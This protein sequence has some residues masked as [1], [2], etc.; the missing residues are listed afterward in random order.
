MATVVAAKPDPEVLVR[1]L[2]E[3]LG[4]REAGGKAFN[5]SRAIAVGLPVPPGIVITNVVFQRFLDETTLRRAIDLECRGLDARFPQDLRKRSRT[6]GELIRAAPFPDRV[7]RLLREW[8]NARSSGT[9]IAV[10][11][12]AVGEDSAQASFAGQLDSRLNID[13]FEELESAV[14][15]CWA[16]YWSERALFYQAALRSG[17]DGMGV[18][19][20]EQ[21]PAAFAGV[22]FTRS[23]DAPDSMLGEY[24][25]GLADTLVSGGINPGRFVIGR[26]DDAWRNERS[27]EDAA[28]GNDTLLLNHAAMAALKQLGMKLESAFGGPQD[29]EWALDRAGFLWCVQSRPI[30]AT[31]LTPRSSPRLIVWSNAN[32]SENFPAPISPLLYSIASEG[33]YHY[34]RNLCRAFGI[35]P[36]RIR[37]MEQPLRN[38][39]GVHGARMYYNLTSI[40][41]I[42]RAAPFGD[43]LVDW[44]NAFTGA[45]ER[46]SPPEQP[47]LWSRTRMSR[48][49][50]AGEAVRMALKTTWQYLFLR[51]CIER[52]ERTAGEFSRRT[53]PD[54]LDSR[55]L[56]ELLE[57]LRDFL[58]I[59]RNRWTDASLA[60]AGSMICYGALKAL[61][62]RALPEAGAPPALHNTLLKALPDVVSGVPV[63]E[64]WNLS[65]LIR[66]DP[67]LAGLFVKHDGVRILDHLRAN[68]AFESFRREFDRFLEEWGFRSSSELML[69]V[70][71]FQENPAPL[72]DILKGYAS[73][74]GDSPRDIMRKHDAERVTETARLMDALGRQ[75]LV[76][77][78]PLLNWSGVTRIVLRW[79]QRSIVYRERARLQQALL[80]SRCRRIALAIGARLA[81]TGR[82]GTADDIFF[83]TYQEIEALGSGAAMFPHGVRSL[84]E[85][86]RAQH[87]ELSA[88]CPPDSFTLPEGEYL[89]AG[90][91]PVV[92]GGH[93]DGGGTTLTGTG[94]CGGK[95]TGPAAIL[96]S[97]AESHLIRAGD[98]LVTKQTDPGWAPVFFLIKGLVIERGGMLSHGAIIAREFG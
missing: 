98:I 30:T 23:P 75:S 89:P 74:T 60:D 58:D 38:I 12:S 84:I 10:R 77:W 65:R 31:R 73:L 24:C 8:W 94:A 34:F 90:K 41:A 97:V 36:R 59:R 14:M 63:I 76:P 46:P 62:S 4:A 2:A 95:V 19:V 66:D 6:I 86:R 26:E 81:E 16:S 88:M 39:I 91:E 43:W 37:D 67:A 35:S 20:Q 71:G 7:R 49:V 47:E 25:G 55:P 9:L 29:V 13:S 51:R 32:V 22:L 45:A 28:D 70:P 11:S 42:L 1:S 56:D 80:Y 87:A 3:P 92:P 68:D 21:V 64:L 79:T 78:L 33:Y 82:L 83:L 69:T 96:E 27:P 61:L 52:F 50:Q 57:D 93:V 44:F 48:A 54:A 72:L 53:H 40:H 85:L 15:S 18:I 5:L 17:L